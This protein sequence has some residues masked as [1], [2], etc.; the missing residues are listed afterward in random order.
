M[1]LEM[2]AR[3]L[4]L[5]GVWPDPAALV[6][7]R[8]NASEIPKFRSAFALAQRVGEIFT[9]HDADWVVHVARKSGIPKLFGT[10]AKRPS[11]PAPIRARLQEYYRS[12]ICRLER[13][14]GRD[15][16]MWRLEG[17]EQLPC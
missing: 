7:D 3:F 14:L 15:L 8:V 17:M 6:R 16:E 13:L 9:R 12:E 11:L 1:N 10:S 2:I 4:G 5:S